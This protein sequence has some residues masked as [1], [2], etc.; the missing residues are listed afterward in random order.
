MS[1]DATKLVKRVQEMRDEG[2]LSDAI[3]REMVKQL[4]SSDD[5]YNFVGVY[6]H[7][8]EES[9]LWLHNYVGEST[10]HAR[11]TVGE[12]VCGTA[13]SEKKDQNVGD[14]STVDNYIACSPRTKSELVIL[15]RA[16][17]DIFGQIDID[18]R[19]KNAFPDKVEDN[20]RMI[21]DKLAEVFVAE[22]RT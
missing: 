11:I 22:R 1:V 2:Y 10:E 4:K 3:L 13:V 9:L 17:D 15:I 14:V 5:R 6:L 16:G 18:A 12:G 8:P 21:A 20:V 19:E 7:N